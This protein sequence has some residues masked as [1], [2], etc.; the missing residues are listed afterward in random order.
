MNSLASRD[1]ENEC[2]SETASSLLNHKN[3]LQY[4]GEV[5]SRRDLIRIRIFSFISQRGRDHIVL[6]MAVLLIA[7]G[8]GLTEKT[9]G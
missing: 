7:P 6:H 2:K 8:R 9:E 4:S 3:A 1:N 5:R